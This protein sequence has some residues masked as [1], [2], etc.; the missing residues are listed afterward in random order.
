[1]EWPLEALRVD[2]KA[3]SSTF[4]QSPR[5]SVR[6]PDEATPGPTDRANTHSPMLNIPAPLAHYLAR[7][8]QAGVAVLKNSVRTE[9]WTSTL[10]DDRMSLM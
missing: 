6:M 9:P 8:G 5:S 2:F 1:M 10:Y 4:G 3:G 7:R